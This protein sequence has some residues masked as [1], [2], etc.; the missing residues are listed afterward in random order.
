MSYRNYQIEPTQAPIPMA[1]WCAYNPD[2]PEGSTLLAE[3]VQDAKSQI[4]EIT[5]DGWEDL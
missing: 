2:D 5:Q 3:S 4:D 1:Q